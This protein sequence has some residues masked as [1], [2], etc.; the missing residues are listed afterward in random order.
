MTAV[1][2]FLDSEWNEIARIERE[3]AKQKSIRDLREALDR[4]LRGVADA[5]EQTKT[6]YRKA[7]PMDV[8]HR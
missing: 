1:Q 6:P 4:A 5:K 2:D 7:P 3:M 8:L